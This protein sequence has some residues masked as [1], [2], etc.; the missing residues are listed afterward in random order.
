MGGGGYEE[1]VGSACEEGGTWRVH[2][3][4]V[5]GGGCVCVLSLWGEWD[6][7]GVGPLCEEQGVCVCSGGASVSRGGGRR[8]GL[9]SL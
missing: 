1:G 4:S 2:G 7:S 8:G 6:D 5:G 9:R 3:L